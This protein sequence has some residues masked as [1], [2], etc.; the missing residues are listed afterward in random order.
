MKKNFNLVISDIMMPEMDGLEL[1]RRIKKNIN[2]NHIPII[3]LTA[4][5]TPERN[6]ESLNLGADAYIPKPFDITILQKTALNLIQNRKLLKNTFD[7]SQLQKD[8]VKQVALESSDEILLKKIISFINENLSNSDLNVEMIANAVGISRVHLYRKLKDL[9]NQSASDLIKNIRLQQ[10]ADL[11]KS[12]QISVSEVAYAVGFSNLSTFS[13]NFKNLHGE[14][15][16][17]FQDKHL[18]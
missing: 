15:P 10:A 5:S 3:L 17:K 12:K 13:T 18:K 8:K 4:K 6:M 2:I 14:S 16:K 7:G 11:L 9:T 1:C